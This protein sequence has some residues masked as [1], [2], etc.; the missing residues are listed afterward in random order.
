[1][2][3]KINQSLWAKEKKKQEGCTKLFPGGYR[4]HL[5]NEEFIAEQEADER[6]RIEQLAQKTQRKEDHEAK[7]SHRLEAEAEWKTM[8]DGHAKAV[9]EWEELVEKLK[10]ENV[11]RKDLPKK[12]KRPK[13]P[14]PVADE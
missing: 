6:D 10:A 2:L 4:H 12:L 5:T 9:S 1:M 11:C 8:L 13:K 3:D 14:K 7:R